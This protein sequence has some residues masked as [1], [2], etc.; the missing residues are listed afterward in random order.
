MNPHTEKP[1]L[2]IRR[3]GVHSA[4]AH[5][6]VDLDSQRPTP[7]ALVVS[8]GPTIQQAHINYSSSNEHDDAQGKYGS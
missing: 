4:S 7:L 1:T 3:K 6:S 8:G 2:S 5:M